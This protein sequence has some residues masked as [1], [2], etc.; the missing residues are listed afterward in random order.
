MQRI[1]SKPLVIALFLL[2]GPAVAV[3]QKIPESAQTQLLEYKP[4]P[5]EGPADY[6][7][8]AGYIVGV[9]VSDVSAN[10]RDEGSGTVP[11][12]IGFATEG[13]YSYYRLIWPCLVQGK[14]LDISFAVGESGNVHKTF[15]NM[16]EAS[17]DT[18]TPY[19]VK[20]PQR[21]KGS[22]INIHSPVR[23]LS[24]TS[25]HPG[26]CSSN[27]SSIGPNRSSAHPIDILKKYPNTTSATAIAASV[28]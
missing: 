3:A 20:P 4:N 9:L 13:R 1:L 16:C 28:T 24:H 26:P 5:F 25:P 17:T 7:P 22:E 14:G 2:L 10:L 27:L 19:G 6:K 18:A 23:T 15:K 8:L 11:K 21:Q 12:E